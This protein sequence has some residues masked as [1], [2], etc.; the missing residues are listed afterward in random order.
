MHRPATREYGWGTPDSYGFPE[1]LPGFLNFET[2]GEALTWRT[3][4]GTD[5]PLFTT[6]TWPPLRDPKGKTV[7]PKKKLLDEL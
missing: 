7:S 6:S 5:I 2:H 1:N 3:G 4:Q